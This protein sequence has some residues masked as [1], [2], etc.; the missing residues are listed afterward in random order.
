MK[1]V[2]LCF[3]DERVD[4]VSCF[5][6]TKSLA[7]KHAIAHLKSKFP[8]LI[9]DSLRLEKGDD[10]F[11]WWRYTVQDE[12]EIIDFTSYGTKAEVCDIVRKTHGILIS[13]KPI[14]VK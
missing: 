12:V 11:G 1:Y 6:A 3:V 13:R 7:L 2:Y 10:I 14:V 4:D 5:Y 9:E 8:G